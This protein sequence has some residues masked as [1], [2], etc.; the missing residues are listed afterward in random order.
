MKSILIIIEDDSDGRNRRYYKK[1]D[2]E[3]YIR[4]KGLLDYT[5]EILDKKLVKKH[6]EQPLYPEGFEKGLI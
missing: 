1:I 3:D 6:E 2:W 4:S 5:V